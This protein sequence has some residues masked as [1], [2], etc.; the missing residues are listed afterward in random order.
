[1]GFEPLNNGK[2]NGYYYITVIQ[3]VK[4]YME[5]IYN[6]KLYRKSHYS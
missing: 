1:M 2:H 3:S 4:I 6:T 5:S